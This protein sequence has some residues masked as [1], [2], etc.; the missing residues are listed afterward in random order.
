[1]RASAVMHRD[2][3]QR[4][5]HLQSGITGADR[6][7]MIMKKAAFCSN[8]MLELG[9][10]ESFGSVPLY[11]ENTS[12]LHIASNRTYSP[13]AK[14]IALK[15]Y[16][17]VQK[18]VKESKVIIHYSKSE[19]QLADLVTDLLSKHSHPNLIKLINEFKT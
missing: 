13:R 9:V 3:R 6:T 18:L 14:H 16:L 19:D 7:A 8:T 11:I 5:H 12:A 1:M 2:A 17:F 4:S 10:D 15:Y